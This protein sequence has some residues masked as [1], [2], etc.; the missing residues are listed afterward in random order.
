[1]EQLIVYDIPE[2]KLRT[3]VSHTL[4]DYGYERV[5]YSVFKGSRSQNVLEMLS[6]ELENLIGDEEADVR[7][8]QVCDRCLSKTI[9]VSR[10]GLDETE[11]VT[12]PCQT[13]TS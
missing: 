13:K 5:Q 6:Q 8:Y 7:F 10:I 12:F 4:E 2:D 1:M 11:G 9:V 3:R